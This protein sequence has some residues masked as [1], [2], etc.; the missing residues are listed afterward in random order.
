MKTYQYILLD[1]DGTLA[2]TLDLW[3]DA[4]RVVLGKRGLHPSDY[5]IARSFGASTRY[6]TEFGVKDIPV[7][8]A[9]ADSLAKQTLP[10][11]H[12]YPGAARLLGDLKARDKHLALLTSS[13]HENIHHLLQDYNLLNYFDVII[14]AEDITNHKP[15]PESLEKAMMAMGAVKDQTIII[16]DSDKDLGAARNLGIDA[17]LSY[18]PEHMKFYSLDEL[19]SFKPTYIVDTLAEINDIVI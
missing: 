18:P 16:G 3:L 6:L 14:A 11:V 7:A 13:L 8:F 17:I 19:K 1:W 12:L 9:E 10:N 4:F 2:K 15:H 5:E